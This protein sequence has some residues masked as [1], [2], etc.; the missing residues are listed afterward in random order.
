MKPKLT[1]WVAFGLSIVLG[2]LIWICSPRFTGLAEPWDASGYYWQISL[3]VA[4]F[5]PAVFS[6]Q[7]F[8]LWPFGVLFGQLV[9]FGVRVI[10]GPPSAL[11]PVGVMYLV[12]FSA[13]TFVGAFIGWASRRVLGRMFASCQLHHDA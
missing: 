6:P 1:F 7:R 10:Q 3:L 9:V 12:L 4:G 2:A 8:W 13:L 5:L 11:W